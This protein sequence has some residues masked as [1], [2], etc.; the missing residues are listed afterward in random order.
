MGDYSPIGKKGNQKIFAKKGIASWLEL[1]VLKELKTRFPSAKEMF[2]LSSFISIS[3][4]RRKQ[5]KKRKINSARYSL[6]EMIQKTR[7]KIMQ[8]RSKSKAK[9]TSRL[10]LKRVFQKL[11]KRH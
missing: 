10:K 5:L 3:S 4:E 9:K 6:D 1:I 2:H 8:N 7:R 11:I